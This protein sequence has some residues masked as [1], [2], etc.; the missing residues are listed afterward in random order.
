MAAPGPLRLD[1]SY[2]NPFLSHTRIP[3]RL[4]QGALVELAVYDLAGRRVRHLADGWRDGGSRFAR[5]DGRD[6]SG[7]RLAS[8]VYFVRLKVGEEIR[9]RRLVLLR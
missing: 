4:P 5:W 6:D 3:Y 1:A 8:G 2:P 7:R 9:S